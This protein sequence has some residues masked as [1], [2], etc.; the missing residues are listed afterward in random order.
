[1]CHPL[2]CPC[3]SLLPSS[4]VLG[5]GAAPAYPAAPLAIIAVHGV[6]GVEFGAAAGAVGKPRVDACWRQPAP[7]ILGVSDG[8]QAVGPNAA[9]EVE[10]MVEVVDDREL[11]GD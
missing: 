9:S 8:L 3:S 6:G 10:G 7:G 2:A 1:M 4:F 5:V 11:V